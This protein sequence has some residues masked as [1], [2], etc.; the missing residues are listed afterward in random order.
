M[1][2]EYRAVQAANRAARLDAARLDVAGHGRTNHC[3]RRE[4]RGCTD[5]GR[6][7]AGNRNRRSRAMSGGPLDLERVASADEPTP[8]NGARERRADS[9]ATGGGLDAE[10][11]EKPLLVIESSGGWPS[12]DLRDLWAHRDLFYFLVWR[13][14][15]VR[16]KQTA[17]GVAW[18]VLQPLL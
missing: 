13:D 3:D 1:A 14:V 9:P 18:A 6:R 7:A 5:T 12:L 11:P 10:L 16:Y 15:K 17:L 4:Y 2:C 8:R